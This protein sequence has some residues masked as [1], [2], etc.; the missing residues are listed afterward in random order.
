M[1]SLFV[2][3]PSATRSAPLE[4]PLGEV[5]EEAREEDA[6]DEGGEDAHSEAA[7]RVPSRVRAQAAGELRTAGDAYEVCMALFAEQLQR[8]AAEKP[9]PNRSI[10]GD[11]TAR[12]AFLLL[13]TDIQQRDLFL[14]TAKA[15]VNWSRLRSLVGAPPYHFLNPQDAAVLNASGFARGRANMAYE[16]MHRIA[17]HSQ[18][19]SGQLIDEHT[20]EYRIVPRAVSDD[21]PLPGSEYLRSA[22][23]LVL[24]VKV[25]RH[26]LEKKRKLFNSAFKKELFFPQVGE[27]IVLRESN[28]LMSAR[29]LQQASA[30]V[31]RVKALWPRGQGASTAAVLVGL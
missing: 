20:R 8:A 1:A 2:P 18:F 7:S 30:T 19:G 29:G 15:A 10:R 14:H 24:H 11:S 9:L 27:S 23:D 6:N 5:P 22:K 28:A 26:G 12:A 4:E 16:T 21:D 3:P 17:N 31:M 25:K 13:L